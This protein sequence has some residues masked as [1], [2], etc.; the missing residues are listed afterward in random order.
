MKVL[1]L[2]MRNGN[3]IEDTGIF[4]GYALVLILPMRNGNTGPYLVLNKTYIPL[5]STYEEWK[6]AMVHGTYQRK[7]SV[8]IL[9]MRNGNTEKNIEEIFTKKFLSYL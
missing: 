8:L 3:K 9:P 6:Q 4:V 2:P 7:N 5:L 1:I